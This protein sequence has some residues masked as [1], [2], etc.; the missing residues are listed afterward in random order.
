[1]TIKLIKEK[2]V[3]GQTEIKIVD[4]DNKL[5]SNHSGIPD[6]E[7]NFKRLKEMLERYGDISGVEVLDEFT[8]TKDGGE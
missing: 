3:T 4:G 8:Y 6:A 7:V 2:L 1:M 5:I